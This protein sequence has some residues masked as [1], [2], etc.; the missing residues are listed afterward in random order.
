MHA[1]LARSYLARLRPDLAEKL[2]PSKEYRPGEWI[3]V[4]PPLA[5]IGRRK[6][7]RIAAHLAAD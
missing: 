7:R 5:V 6:L 3:F 2:V 1:Q 4:K